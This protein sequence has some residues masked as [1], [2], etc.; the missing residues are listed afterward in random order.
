LRTYQVEITETLQR[1][2]DVMADTAEEAVEDVTRWYK[3]EEIILDS[4]D[5]VDFAVEIFPEEKKM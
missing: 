2:V 1:I 3:G 4:E 5:F